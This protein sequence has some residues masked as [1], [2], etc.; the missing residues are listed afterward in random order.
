M[1][2]MLIALTLAATTITGCGLAGAGGGLTDMFSGI[3]GCDIYDIND[4]G[5]VTA[6]EVR[7]V[8]DLLGF[9]NDVFT[10]AELIQA[11]GV[12]GCETQ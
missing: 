2:K 9:P 5:V 4:D 10:D 8:F 3:G 11:L 6:E 12:L 1:H 7:E